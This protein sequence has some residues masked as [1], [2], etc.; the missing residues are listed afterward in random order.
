MKTFDLLSMCVRNLLRR[1]LRTVL[2]AVGVMIG[3]CAIIITISLGLGMTKMQN[4]ALAQMGDLTRIDIYNYGGFRG[5]GNS[6]GGKP[7]VLD[8][9]ALKKISKLEG[10][11]VVTPLLEEYNAVEVWSGDRYQYS[12]SIMGIYP[13]AM[14]KLGYTAAQGTLLTSGGTGRSIHIIF[15]TEAA[16]QFSNVKRQHSQVY[17]FPDANGN[18][19]DPYV[20]AMKDE[21]KIR[22]HRNDEEK[23]KLVEYDVQVD[24]VLETGASND[25]R[26]NYSIYMSIDDLNRL[27]MEHKRLNK[28]K[29]NQ[30]EQGYRN[31]IVKCTDIEYVQAVEEYIKTEL[32]FDTNSM[33]SIRKPIQEQIRST[34]FILGGLGLISLLVA[35]IGIANTMVMSIYERTREIGIMKVLGCEVPHIRTMFLTEAGIIGLIGGSVGVVVSL[36]M[37]WCMNNWST[38]RMA[39]GLVND[40][41]GDGGGMGGLFG[42]LGGMMG[43]GG[44]ISLIPPW[45][46]A[47]AMVFGIVIGI[48]SGFIPANRA[49]KVSALEAIKHE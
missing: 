13:E 35:A 29:E 22:L 21:F 1:K 49:V 37:S 40:A 6:T 25:Y 34:T 48:V 14:E 30:A 12:G 8:D 44:E 24:G 17:P 5:G 23:M 15:G 7:P 33:E 18:I 47:L 4:D 3:S 46:V 32:G 42:G 9:A 31:A 2:T 39:L 45:L 19:P 41:Q 27:S 43:G 28:V 11:D 38:I 26:A 16:Y 10:V 36:G 20:D